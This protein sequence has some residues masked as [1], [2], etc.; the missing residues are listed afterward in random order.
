MKFRIVFR[1]FMPLCLLLPAVISAQTKE[2]KKKA[3][4]EELKA[5]ID[6]RQYT[7]NAQS[8]TSMGGRTRQLSSL[9]T[10][11]IHQ[12]SLD[13]DLPYFGRAYSAPLD[14]SNGGIHFRSVSFGYEQTSSKQGGWVIRITPAGERS[15]SNM[16]MTISSTGYA[17]LQVNSNDRQMIS[18]Y[19]RVSGNSKKK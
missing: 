15:A 2:D 5:H 7:F 12:D 1:L 17:T 19:G 10:L 16:Q 6:A 8:A 13:A 14:N 11:K 4:Y 9:Y 3:Q 18:F